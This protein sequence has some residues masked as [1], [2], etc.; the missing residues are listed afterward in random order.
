MGNKS[1][2]DSTRKLLLVI[3]FETLDNVHEYR[4]AVKSIGLNINDCKVIAIV[5]SKKESQILS[6]IHSVVYA[7]DKEITLLGK[8]KNNDA[9]KAIGEFYDLIVVFGNHPAKVQRQLKK[10]KNSISVGINTNADFLTI[11]LKSEQKA[12]S[13]LLNF[14]KSTLEKIN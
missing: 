10:V 12:P 4:N 2:W 6:P 5:G 13:Q 9:N 14:A 3:N 8:W 11:D 7:S 1:Y